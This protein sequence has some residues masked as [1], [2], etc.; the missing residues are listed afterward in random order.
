MS[1]ILVPTT[2]ADAWKG[3][4][5]DPERQWR[6]G[7]SARTLA[8][9]WQDA[10]GFP[11]SVQSAFEQSPDPELHGIEM[12]VGLPEHKVMLPGGGRASQTDLFVLGR[13]ADGLVSIAV[14]GKVAEPFGQHVGEWLDVEANAGRRRRL[15]YVEKTLGLPS[16]VPSDIRY[17]LLHRTASAVIEAGR[18]TARR[19]VMLVHAFGDQTDDAFA[20]FAAFAGLLGADPVRGAVTRAQTRPDLYLGWVDG[21]VRYLAT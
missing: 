5:A 19:A 17:Q 21:E 16:G 4:L 18:F 13:T 14:E 3:F 2:T 12:L 15:A 9:C 1:E 7:Y 10:R 11:A 20:D 8:H 6:V